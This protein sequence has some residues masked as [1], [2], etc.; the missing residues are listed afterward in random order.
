MH[1]TG[2]RALSA[3]AVALGLGLCAAPNSAQYFDGEASGK[4]LY[5]IQMAKDG[6][7][8]PDSN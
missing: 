3:L 6:Y 4:S 8:L 5:K 7:Q 1:S 2:S